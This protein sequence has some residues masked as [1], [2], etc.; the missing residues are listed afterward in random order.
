MKQQSI[1]KQ[2][3]VVTVDRVDYQYSDPFD[4]STRMEEHHTLGFLHPHQPQL[5][6]DAKRKDTQHYWAG[7][8]LQNDQFMRS[9]YN[10]FNR[11]RQLVPID[12]KHEPK[13]WENEPL[14]G[15]VLIDTVNRYRGNKLFKVMDPRG[16]EFEITVQSLFHILC[17]GTVSNGKIIDKCVWKANKNLIIAS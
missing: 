5:R 4:Y 16:I 17:E 8:T 9:E 10:G 12:P 2:L 1:P 15:F 6:A 14:D 13:I 11:S 3:Y 7:I